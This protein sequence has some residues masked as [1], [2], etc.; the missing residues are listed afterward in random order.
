[1]NC[2]NPNCKATD[3]PEDARFCPDCGCN[4]IDFLYQ[5]ERQKQ[6]EEEAEAER[7]RVQ[8]EKEEYLRKREEERRKREDEEK[9]K[10]EEEKNKLRK[11]ELKKEFEKEVDLTFSKIEPY[12]TKIE[13][14]VEKKWFLGYRFTHAFIDIVLI[15][16]AIGGLVCSFSLILGFME[17]VPNP[18][19]IPCAEINLLGAIYF[20]IGL[21]INIT[22]CAF[23]LYF[24]LAICYSFI[25]SPMLL[26]QY[27]RI[28]NKMNCPD[29]IKDIMND[30]FKI[31][32]W[33]EDNILGWRNKSF[34]MFSDKVRN[35]IRWK[36]RSTP[37]YHGVC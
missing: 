22:I 10:Q 26:K 37:K 36:L 14:S 17:E 32:T 27:K 30:V 25:L 4:I 13:E 9:K 2:P 12:V 35:G 29:E 20:L 31:G 8:K 6:R 21:A 5:S 33:E 24:L 3:L 15:G 28:F 7:L 19:G 23:V 1:M 34:G 16:L 11:E 18:M